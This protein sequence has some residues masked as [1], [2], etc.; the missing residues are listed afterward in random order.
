MHLAATLICLLGPSSGRFLAPNLGQWVFA[1]G[2]KATFEFVQLQKK[3]A[4]DANGK[5]IKWDPK[6][7]DFMDDVQNPKPDDTL[8]V[9][10]IKSPNPMTEDPHVQFKL[11][12]HIHASQMIEI[13]HPDTGQDDLACMPASKIPLFEDISVGLASGPWKTVGWAEFVKRRGGFSPIKNGGIAFGPVIEEIKP[14]KIAP[15]PTRQ[16]QCRLG[17]R[18]GILHSDYRVIVED[19]SGKEIESEYQSAFLDEDA[20]PPTFSGE[21]PNWLRIVIQTRELRWQTINVPV[22][23]P[24]L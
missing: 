7:D 10:L 9:V 18:S 17:N 13:A 20:S 3:L 16:F 8:L 19:R 14:S 22:L 12:S 6:L 21:A 2:A 1:N 15:K 11:P 23:K 5:A 4:W 24:K